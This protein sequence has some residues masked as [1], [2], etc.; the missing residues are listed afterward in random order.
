[1]QYLCKKHNGSLALG[2]EWMCD[3][4]STQN[5]RRCECGRQ[6][7][8]FGEALMSSITCSCGEFLQGVDIEN[9]RDLWNQGKRGRIY[10][11]SGN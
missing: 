4:C 1:M 3:V 5:I 6:P 8:Y 11:S 2:D 10:G 9:I 7:R